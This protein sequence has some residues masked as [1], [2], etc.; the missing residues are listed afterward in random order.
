[1]KRFFFIL[2]WALIA[3]GAWW[4]GNRPVPLAL[5]FDEPFASVSFAPYRFGESPISHDYPTP[6]EI[7]ADLA[8]L[9]GVTKGIRT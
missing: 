5:S 4:W 6:E 1:M 8:S 9:K 7:D 2:F 3:C